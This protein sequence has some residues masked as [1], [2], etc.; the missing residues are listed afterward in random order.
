MWGKSQSD[1]QT[2]IH[3]KH[4]LFGGHND[5]E[6]PE[7]MDGYFPLLTIASDDKIGFEH[8]DYDGLI[9]AITEEALLER[10][11]GEVILIEEFL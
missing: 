2:Q 1:E 7:K 3:I 6:R 10:N 9:F 11:F 4:F 8:G 5:P